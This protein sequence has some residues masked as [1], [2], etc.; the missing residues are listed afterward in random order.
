MVLPTAVFLM[1][2][3][4]AVGEIIAQYLRETRWPG[5]GISLK[6]TEEILLIM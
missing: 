5:G 3:T 2:V 4:P 6:C 1:N